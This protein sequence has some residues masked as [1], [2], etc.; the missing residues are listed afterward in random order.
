MRLRRQAL[1]GLGWGIGTASSPDWRQ[2]LRRFTH[3]LSRLA[4]AGILKRPQKALDFALSAGPRTPIRAGSSGLEKP[5][6]GDSRDPRQGD[7]PT[8]S[9]ASPLSGDGNPGW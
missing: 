9:L 8:E 1:G 5:P 3:L 4:C 2:S 7:C 6:A